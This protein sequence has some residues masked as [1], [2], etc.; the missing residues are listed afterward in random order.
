MFHRINES[1][2][3]GMHPAISCPRRSQ[4]RPLGLSCLPIRTFGTVGPRQTLLQRV[5]LFY[6]NATVAAKAG[7][8][9][10]AAD[11]PRRAR[12]RRDRGRGRRARRRG[13]LQPS[14]R[15][16]P[17]TSGTQLSPL[18]CPFPAIRGAFD[19]LEMDPIL[20]GV[21]PG[22]AGD[23]HDITR[24]EGFLRDAVARQPIRIRPFG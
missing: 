14:Y 13:L 22:R 5:L 4:F 1:M 20:A 8:Y 23:D 7:H 12:L 18:R 10:L 21:A 11:R 16:N 2:G 17:A 9:T 3:L 6:K 19:A 24:L 15:S